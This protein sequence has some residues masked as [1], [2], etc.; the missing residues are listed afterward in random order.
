MR[1]LP[2]AIALLT[3]L[4]GCSPVTVLNA[5]TSKTGYEVVS[6]LS[7]GPHHRQKLDL[8]IP[9]NLG[10]DAPLVVFFYGG[11]WRSGDRAAY[12]FVGEALAAQGFMVAI[13]DYRLYP[14]VRFPTFVEDGAVAVAHLLDATNSPRTSGRKT[15]LMGHSAGAHTV[16]TLT[17]D[18]SYLNAVG[19]DADRAIAGSVGLSGPYDFAPIKGA[20]LKK[21]FADAEPQSESQPISFARG[22]APPLLLLHGQSDTTVLVRNSRNLAERV[23]DLGGQAAITEYPKVGHAPLIGAFAKPLRWLAP[24]LDDATAFVERVTRR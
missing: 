7:Y 23:R 9:D 17:L 3:I 14:E 18:R 24:S 22:D 2:I 16:M 19:L 1:L 4:P 21:I 11:G 6:G 8:Y 5:S 12:L 13:P 20:R 15:V 10:D